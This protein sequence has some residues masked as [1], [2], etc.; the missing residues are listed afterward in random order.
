MDEARG[1]VLAAGLGTRLRPLSD[2][3]PK[4][5]LPVAGATL[6][7][8]AIA[9]LDQAG[10]ERIAVNLHHRADRIAAHLAARPDAARFHLSREPEILGTG[11]ALAGARAFLAGARVC[12]VYNGDVLCDLDLSVLLAAHLCR[13]AADLAPALATLALVD[14]PVVNSV[15]LGPDG[16]VRDI[17]GRL[18]AAAAAP[19]GCRGLTFTG[20]ACY[21]RA[22]LDRV[23]PGPG[24]LVDVLVTLLRERPGAIRGHVHTGAWEDLGTL[25]RYLDAHRRLL[26]PGF[27]S[28][29]AGARLPPAGRLDEC[30]V[31]PDAVVPEGMSLRRAVCGDGWVVAEDA[32][33]W[34]EL[35][36][37][38]AAGFAPD[39]PCDLRWITGHG[40]DRRFV[41]VS[42]ANR[43]AMLMLAPPGDPETVRYLA[44]A[45][46]LTD[47]GLGAPSL[48]AHDPAT[49]AVLLEDLG[50]ETLERLV[51]REPARAGELYAAV[52]DRLADLQT[53]GAASRARCPLAW[54][55]CFDEAYLRWETGYFR[56]RFLVGHAGLAVA[57]LAVLDAEFAALAGAC[58]RQPY[59]LVHRDFQ[60][61]NILLED[62][63][64]RLVDL[65]GMRW[66][67]VAYDAVSLAWDPYV[68]LPW[69]Q[70]DELLAT[71]PARL[72]ARG[73]RAIATADWQAMTL[74]AGL[75]RLMQA[76]GAYAYLAHVKGRTAFL[77]HVPCALAGLLRALDLAAQQPPSL[78]GPPPLP[79]LREVVASVARSAGNDGP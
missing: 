55:R 70:R 6:L 5:L 32:A 3:V 54:D 10:I 13:R 15:L 78:Y 74:A 40:S 29:A 75:Q 51:A 42:Q 60:S 76:L 22:F 37:I 73:G 61:Q 56:E 12:V 69:D 33:S 2:H 20:I 24:S 53:A 47:C 52:L 63:V 38:A 64:V 66:G 59:T 1:F 49:G 34:P 16:G 48:L 46:F 67:P 35:K 21:D 43:R 23:P 27:V 57:D 25:P 36:V 14:W 9:A 77:A 30:V 8:R 7:D 41:R 17:A 45:A 72:A 31:L 62:G 68:G 11:G 79:A 28:A 50:D 26:G 44:I 18:G 39:A 71:F 58:L 65:Q 4:P 19:A